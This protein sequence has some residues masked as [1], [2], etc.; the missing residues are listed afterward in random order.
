MDFV[1]HENDPIP[2]PTPQLLCIYLIAGLSNP[3]YNS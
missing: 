1:E 2:D 3:N